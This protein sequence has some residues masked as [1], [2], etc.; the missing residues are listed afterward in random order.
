[1]PH[2]LGNERVLNTTAKDLNFHLQLLISSLN[3][4]I[5]V[6][7]SVILYDKTFNMTTFIHLQLI[8][9]FAP[10][11]A[12]HLALQPRLHGPQCTHGRWCLMCLLFS[13][14]QGK[15]SKVTGF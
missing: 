9:S 14:A 4:V 7:V 5:L 15:E 2:L 11:G 13:A 12:H 3:A 10:R 8:D 1:M 6:V